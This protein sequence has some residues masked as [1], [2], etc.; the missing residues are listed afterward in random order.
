MTRDSTNTCPVAV[1]TCTHRVPIFL[2]IFKLEGILTLKSSVLRLIFPL[3][4]VLALFNPIKCTARG[5]FLFSL[6][7]TCKLVLTALR[8]S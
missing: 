3:A 2:E 5:H 7:R 6:R 8:T 4:R 1:D